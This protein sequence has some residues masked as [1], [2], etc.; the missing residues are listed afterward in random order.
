[1]KGWCIIDF[2]INF[3]MQELIAILKHLLKNYYFFNFYVSFLFKLSWTIHFLVYLFIQ[4]YKCIWKWKYD[5]PLSMWTRKVKFSF[6]KK[7]YDF[8][9]ILCLHSFFFLFYSFTT[10]NVSGYIKVNNS[11][12]GE[13]EGPTKVVFLSCNNFFFYSNGILP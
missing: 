12:A 10:V 13:K 2:W 1:M 6:S 4:K 7:C 3:L 5:F 9:E 8:S 11:Y